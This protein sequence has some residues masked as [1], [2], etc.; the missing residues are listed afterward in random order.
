MNQDEEWLLN[1][2]YLGERTE[3]FFA[4]CERLAHGEP[5]AYVI[6]H[7][8]F[9]NTTIF[10]DSRPL[11]PR[12]ETEY[13]V[14]ECMPLI[15]PTATVLDLCAGSGA[16]GVAVAKAL[17]ATQI[18]FGEIDVQHHDTIKKNI[19]LN[20]IAPSRTMIWGGDLFEKIDRT[21]DV[22][23]ANPPYI[24]ATL[25]RTES[26]V[27]D[28]EPHQAL[29]ANAQGLG[30]IERIIVDAPK[31][32]RNT[33]VLIIEHEPEHTDAI[34]CLGEKNGFTVTTH[35]DQYNVLRYTILVR[36]ESNTVSS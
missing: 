30:V 18:D 27:L 2:K 10:L 5:L 17:P 11:I 31:H 26:S 33:G 3:E 12:A 32:L 34:K 19:E 13:W 20:D 16:I 7:V 29:F 28:Y 21:Y 6:G 14:S 36:K 15:G 24:D 22:I 23:L 9:L 4:D 35:V 25:N 8:P 1:E